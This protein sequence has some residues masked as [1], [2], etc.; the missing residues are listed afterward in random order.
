MKDKG[1]SRDQLVEDRKPTNALRRMASIFEENV[2]LHNVI[3]NIPNPIFYKD[4]QGVYLGCNSAYA[5]QI[6]GLPKEQIVGKTVYELPEAIPPDLAE[7]YHRQDMALIHSADTTPTQTY[8]GTAQYADGTRHDVVYNKATLQDD[9]GNTIGLVGV[10]VD[11]TDQK[12]AEEEREALVEDLARR[13]VQLQTAAEVSQAASSILSLD[14]LLPRVVE[15]IKERFDLYYVG[16]FL[17]EDLDLGIAR[18]DSSSLDRAPSSDSLD[19]DSRVTLR[20]GTGEAGRIMLERGH[21]FRVG[22]PGSMIATCVSQ[23]EAKISLDVGEGAVRFD[24][25]VLPKTRS[26]MALPLRVR[27][28]T[29]G[30]MTIQSVRPAD[31]SDEDITSLQSMADQL[32]NAIRNAQLFER[33]QSSLSETRALYYFSDIVS[34]EVDPQAVYEAMANLLVERLGFANSWVAVLD[35]V[36]AAGVD[37]QATGSRRVLRGVVGAGQG[38]TEEVIKDVTPLTARDNPAVIAVLECQPVVIN[39]PLNDDRAA[40]LPEA[41]RKFMGRLVE[42]PILMSSESTA[43]LEVSS[44]DGGRDVLGVLAG[45][46]PLGTPEISEQDV[47]LLQ[48]VVAQAAA[49]MQRG[50]LFEQLQ[51]SLSETE[52]LYQTT[53]SIGRSQSI[54]NILDSVV[55]VLKFVGMHNVTLRVFTAWSERDLESQQTSASSYPQLMDLYGL[56]LANGHNGQAAPQSLDKVTLQ[57]IQVDMSLVQ[58]FLEDPTQLVEY[59]DV[60]QPRSSASDLT[61]SPADLVPERIKES[62]SRSGWRGAL[63]TG[64]SARGK[65]IGVITFTSEKPLTAFSDRYRQVIPRTVADQVSV[66][67]D[68]ILLV[69]EAQQRAT[70]AEKLSTIEVMLSQANTEEEIL[71][72]VV[73]ALSMEAERSIGEDVPAASDAAP[74]ETLTA[75]L[76]YMD[77][78]PTSVGTLSEDS[79]DSDSNDLAQ[80]PAASAQSVFSRLAVWQNGGIKEDFEQQLDPDVA[81][82]YTAWLEQSKEVLLVSDI[83]TDARVSE[84]QREIAARLG[85]RAMAGML[86]RGA[87]GRWRGM[88]SLTW[89]E[90]R[91][92]TADEHFILDRLNETVEALIARRRAY[93]EQERLSQESQRRALQLQTAADVSRAA[94][95][96]LKLEE[97]LPQAVDLIK[98]RFNLYYAGIFLVDD[99]GQWAI[100]RAGTGEAGE[101]MLGRGHKLA[102]GPGSMIGRCVAEGEPVIPPSIE[103]AK[104]RYDN[105]FLPDT[106]SEIALP[107]ISRGRTIGAMTAQSTISDYFTEESLIVLQTVAG[108]LANAIA[109]ARLYAEVQERV[110]ELQ[111]IQRQYIREA[112]EDFAAEQ[113][114]AEA[115]AASV[116]PSASE[117]SM[118]FIYDLESVEPISAVDE[119]VASEL[120][121]S[122]LLERQRLSLQPIVTERESGNGDGK[123][124]SEGAAEASSA[125]HASIEVRGEPVGLL[126]FEDPE[127]SHEWTEDELAIIEAVRGQIDQAL[128]NRLLSSQT[129][130]ALAETRRREEESRFLQELAAFLNA[131]EDIAAAQAELL[132]R[133]QMFV[134]V[135]SMRLSRYVELGSAGGDYGELQ[136]LG[137]AIGPLPVSS[138]DSAIELVSSFVPPDVTS[139]PQAAESVTPA[140]SVESDKE[141]AETVEHA[142]AWVALKVEP[143]LVEDLRNEDSQSQ[144]FVEDKVLVEAGLVS[145]L[146][147]PLRLGSRLIGTLSLASHEA[148][149]FSRP[150]VLPILTQAAAQIASGIERSNLLRQTQDAL[151]DSQTLYMASSSLAQAT[152]SPEVLRAIV[153][154]AVPP[155][156]DASAEIALFAREP[157][158]DEHDGDTKRPTDSKETSSPE[159]SDGREQQP[160]WVQIVAS[161]SRGSELPRISVDTRLSID[162]IPILRHL[163]SASNRIFVCQDLA[164]ETSVASEIRNFYLNHGVNALIV[165]P[166]V[167]SGR[168]IGVLHLKLADVYQPTDM[169]RRLFRTTSDQAAVVLSNQQLIQ[170][171]QARATQLQAAV[172]M[173]SLT[174]SIMERDALMQNAVDFIRDSFGLYYVGIFL[175]DNRDE[176]TVLQTGTGEP[177]R[178]MLDMGHRL[179][180]DGN[181]PVSKC[182]ATQQPIIALRPDENVEYEG[183]SVVSDEDVH[184]Q[185][186]G[187]VETLWFDNPMLSEARSELAL[188]LESRGRVIGAMTFQS[189]QRLS[190]AQEDVTTYQLMANQLANV[191]ENTNLYEQSQSSLA[192]ASALYR[193]ARR[194]ADAR[195]VREVFMTAVEGIA[196]QGS[197]DFILAGSLEPIQE[198]EY[199][200]IVATWSRDESLPFD[201]EDLPVFP[202]SQIRRFYDQLSLEHRFLAADATQDPLIDPL[203]RQRTLEWG[204]RALAAFQ[205]DIRGLQYGTIMIYSKTGRGFSTSATRFYESI[206]RLAFVALESL[207]LVDSTREEADRRALLNEVLRTASGFLDPHELMRQVTPVIAKGI[208]MP[209]MLWAWEG[210]HARPASICR[211][212]G[213]FLSLSNDVGFQLSEIPLVGDV[214]R[215]RQPV[216][217][218]F[219]RGRS[220][221]RSNGKGKS[222][223]ALTWSYI[224]DS[225]QLEEGYGAPLLTARDQVLGVLVLGRQKGHFSIDEAHQEF[226]RSAST[227]ISVAIETAQLYQE[228]QEAAE[229]AKDAD[230]LKTEFLANMSHEL[231]TPLNSIIG[232]SRVILKGIDGPLTDMQKTDLE[233]IFTSGKHLLNLINDILDISKIEAGKMEFVFESTDIADLAETVMSSTAIALVKDTPVDL[234]SEIPD[235]VPM[236]LADARRIR[237]VITNLLGNAAKFTE[238]GFIRLEVTHDEQWVTVSVQDTGIGIPK[239]RYHVVFKEFEQVDSSSTRRY[240]GTGLGLPVSKK[241]IEAHGGKMWFESAE[242]QGSTFYFSIPINGPGS[243]TSEEAEAREPQAETADEYTILTVDDDEAVITLFRRYLGKQ[244]YNV[245][246]LTNAD[247]VVEEAKRLKPYAITLDIIMPNRDGWQLIQDLKT[248]PET[249]NIPVVV[250]SIVSAADKGL[251]MGVAD[252]LVKPVTERDL[253]KALARLAEGGVSPEDGKGR[254]VLIVDDSPDDRNLLRRILENAN[255][256]VGEAEGGAEAIGRIRDQEPDLLILDLMMP[257]VDGFAVLENLK[258]DERTRQIPVVVVTA[259]ELTSAERG[260]LQRRAEALLQK[261]LFDQEQLLKDVGEALQRIG[262]PQLESETDAER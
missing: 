111:R 21:K 38:A 199:L 201:E 129:Q 174:T 60:Q 53:R 137:P 262:E 231:R 95:S 259:K 239:E 122:D 91:Q 3:D 82:L 100:L 131:T 194:I 77:T 260:R 136:F 32:A 237:Q 229:R 142:E 170:D 119:T 183:A 123:P 190:F 221:G 86:L 139:Q 250:C 232:F 63:S 124:A 158:T 117:M 105:P 112:W 145:R 62:M 157:D 246:G 182:I 28:R 207:H 76:I 87:G 118:G 224:R 40:G 179:R 9:K 67:L 238:E 114:S 132:K 178:K 258:M 159:P 135:D 128:E 14:E 191:L 61:S 188:P 96:I 202:I 108:Q 97:L 29:V 101:A 176:W 215:S 126:S 222:T 78:T 244:G 249:R 70:V 27:G 88:L 154:H 103:K 58:P 211:P 24:N 197:P 205:L 186:S 253:L 240:E 146:V 15:L 45:V 247:R 92:F 64:L 133:L 7:L 225:L 230:R 93:V 245:I 196:E 198:P 47:Q 212:D 12:A 99:S 102:V 80:S 252:Y 44:Q 175:N 26:E 234:V 72:A 219:E 104:D 16:I 192:E 200:N 89:P 46:R 255:Y 84:R 2:R 31:F 148:G 143:W 54:D 236:V 156:V 120:D 177:G 180:I 153:M 25:P 68:N 98:E 71:S 18:D 257:V 189:G 233:A 51:I 4:T 85:F 73:Q 147:L 216:L 141:L 184:W 226:L 165:A 140:E 217:Q 261:G 208:G 56:S 90:P 241:F 256:Q 81:H 161:W 19:P 36:E 149:A 59:V 8:E 125:L 1:K 220:S 242:G 235:D 83:Q 10:I 173:A 248:D 251:S 20:A 48:A 6:L 11:V 34:R 115:T 69:E 127:Q 160:D 152:S 134:T 138:D 42:V 50:R 37:T 206:A 75:S 243:V 203:V 214:I 228:G 155:A 169:D 172:E 181:A 185:T 227:N 65:L 168:S 66:A 74:S 30:A 22:D 35:E 79:T 57:D 195:S 110:D 151:N 223:A 49:A 116:G 204:M 130:R 144:S 106:R 193:I 55:E 23:G 94:S 209:V 33:I 187:D 210:E 254:R 163:D 5:E 171:S 218:N 43:K 107:L 150:G 213:S 162:E 13:T 167:V 166:L 52:M 121:F 41:A 113:L 109:N 164:G 39:D 17:L